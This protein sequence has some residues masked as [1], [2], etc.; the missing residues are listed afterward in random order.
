[1]HMVFACRQI[2]SRAN[3]F[4]DFWR[5]R[6]SGDQHFV[7]ADAS[8]WPSSGHYSYVFLG[9]FFLCSY[10][11]EKE[12]EGLSAAHFFVCMS[13]FLRCSFCYVCLG[14]LAYTKKKQRMR[15][16]NFVLFL[17][18]CFDLIYSIVNVIISNIINSYAMG[19]GIGTMWQ[20]PTTWFISGIKRCLA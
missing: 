20:W 3:I 12:R 13:V 17:R 4:G 18:S 6:A 19:V 1:M 5:N 9:L 8:S 10:P 14:L 11:R 2:Q 7:V 15:E 16:G